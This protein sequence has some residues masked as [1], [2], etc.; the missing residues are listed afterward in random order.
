MPFFKSAE[1]RI[2]TD[3][4][5]A[6]TRPKDDDRAFFA[7]NRL[8]QAERFSGA[9]VLEREILKRFA[10]FLFFLLLQVHLDL[11]MWVEKR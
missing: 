10:E 7:G 6:D 11:T 2:I 1:E 8:G 4:V 5:G 3:A 9:H